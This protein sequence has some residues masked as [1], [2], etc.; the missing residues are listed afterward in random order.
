MMCG[1]GRHQLEDDVPAPRTRARTRRPRQSRTEQR[2][3]QLRMN[4]ALA[5]ELNVLPAGQAKAQEEFAAQYELLP[6][7]L[8]QIDDAAPAEDNRPYWARD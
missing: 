6:P 3:I 7:G 1:L 2:A 8:D 5:E 4:L